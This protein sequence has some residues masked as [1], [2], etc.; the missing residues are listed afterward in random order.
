MNKAVGYDNIS[1]F[2]LRSASTVITP[3]L[4]LFINFCFNHGVFPENC[5]TAKIVPIFKKGNREDPSNYRPIS[6]FTCFS[7]IMEKL[8]HKRLMSF[9]NK[10]KVIQ[11][12]QYVFQSNVSTNHAL[13][14]V[15]SDCFDN[16][17]NSQY[18]GL[19]FL[20]L[21]KAFDTVNHKILLHKLQ[22]YGIRGQ[23]N[24]LLRAFLKRRQYVS[25]D[26]VNS[27]LLYNNIG[28]PQGSILGPLLFLVYINDLPSSV[29]SNP[30][31]FADDTCLICSDQSLLVLTSK[32][33]DDVTGISFWLE[34]NKLTV[35]PSKLYAL[36]IPAKSNETLPLVNLSINNSQ[37]S[38]VHYVKYLG[39]NID[40]KLKFDNHISSITQKISR[41]VV[42]Q[43]KLHAHMC[44]T[45]NLLRFYSFTTFVWIVCLGLHLSLLFEK[46]DV[47]SKHSSETYWWR[48]PTRQ[49]ITVFLPI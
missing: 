40:F 43:T 48:S 34:A 37:I 33:N 45:K 12:H 18:T 6:L 30:R 39:L 44:V 1:P 10:H 46:V 29:T 38:V 23:A 7:K 47:P 19:I 27:P 32:M 5:E 17:N 41:A 11:K 9:L 16:I 49:R 28:V 13:I 21:T 4:Q 20:D 31:L 42:I 26:H 36:I 15:V 35:N 8:I 22:H 3:F 25:T 14:D 2:I 24:D